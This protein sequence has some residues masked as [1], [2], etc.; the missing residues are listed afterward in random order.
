MTELK[1]L[2]S[3]N[4]LALMKSGSYFINVLWLFASGLHSNI[5][6]ATRPSGLVQMQTLR[7]LTSLAEHSEDEQ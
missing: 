1:L 6:A 3:C 4:D 5:G 7:R 2:Q